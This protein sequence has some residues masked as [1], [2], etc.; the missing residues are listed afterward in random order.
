MEAMNT[1]IKVIEFKPDHAVTL[2]AMR[3]ILSK[4]LNKT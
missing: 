3:Y 4:G 2:K 1:Y